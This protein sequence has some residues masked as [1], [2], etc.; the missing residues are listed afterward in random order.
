M[1]KLL[2]VLALVA[3]AACGGDSGT[4]PNSDSIEGTYSLRTINGSPLPFTVQSGTYSYT[5]KTDV[6]TIASNG[7]WTETYTYTETANG[8][9]TNGSDVDGGTWVR[10]GNVVNLASNFGTGG[11]SMTYSNGSLTVSESGFVGVYTR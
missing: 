8:Q 10:A 9:T 11:Y 3:V 7:S 1:R 6:I 5:I 4:N 2:A